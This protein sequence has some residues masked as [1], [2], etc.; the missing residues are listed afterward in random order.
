[1]HFSFEIILVLQFFHLINI[2]C[3]LLIY[4]IKKKNASLIMLMSYYFSALH[5]ISNTYKYP[6]Q[7]YI[8]CN[9]SFLHSLV[10]F[11]KHFSLQLH[12]V[13]VPTRRLLWFTSCLLFYYLIF[14][15]DLSGRNCYLLVF[16]HHSGIRY[17]LSAIPQPQW[18]EL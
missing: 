10:L 3:I 14:H 9:L 18:K 6:L 2:S 4:C 17:F 16:H 5:L 12:M 11:Y 15:Y 1:M 8:H 7:I 13:L